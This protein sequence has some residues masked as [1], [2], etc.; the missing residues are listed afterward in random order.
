MTFPKLSRREWQ[1]LNTSAGW[2]SD[3]GSQFPPRI[4]STFKRTHA[5]DPVFLQ[6][7]RRT[8]ARGF[9]GSGTDENDVAIAWNLVP[10]RGQLAQRDSHRAWNRFVARG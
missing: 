2:V 5:G 1:A 6:E 9:V 8:G 4:R 10:A 7:E 3:S